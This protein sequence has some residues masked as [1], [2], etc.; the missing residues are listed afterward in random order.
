MNKLKL[1]FYPNKVCSL[2]TITKS[3]VS[4]HANLNLEILILFSYLVSMHGVQT[5]KAR[6]EGGREGE[7]LILHR[8]L[9]FTNPTFSIILVAI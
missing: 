3:N 7:E 6:D 1:E 9:T 5:I 8:Y 2:Y 4:N